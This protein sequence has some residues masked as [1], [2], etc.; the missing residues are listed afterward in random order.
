MYIIAKRSD[1]GKERVKVKKRWRVMG[2]AALAL[3]GA[4]LSLSML[5]PASWELAQENIPSSERDFVDFSGAYDTGTRTLRGT[6]RMTLT[7]RTGEALPEIVLRANMNGKMD[8]SL[9][10]SDVKINEQSVRCAADEADSTVLR[11]DYLWKP[12]ETIELSF[13]VLIKA[14]KTDGAAL[15]TLPKL[16]VY[17]NG[18]WR[19]ETYDALAGRCDGPTFDYRVK[20]LHVQDGMRAAFGGELTFSGDGNSPV[21]AAQ[22][23]GAR[24][25]TFALLDGCELRGMAEGVKTTVLAQDWMTARSLCARAQEALR[26]L[27]DIGLA[28]PFPAL[29][30]VQTDTG[31]EDG[32][33]GSGIVALSADGDSERLLQRLTRLIAR[34]TFGVLVGSDAYRE[35]WLS[36]S[37]ASAVELLAYRERKGLHAYETRFFENIEIAARVTRPYGVTVGAGTAAF[38][39]DSEMTQV[40]RDQGAAMLLGVEQAVGEETFLQALDRYA[41]ENAGKIASRAELESALNSASGSDWSGYLTDELSF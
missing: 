5:V 15:V 21:Y 23:Q 19:T 8:G 10:V 20:E 41:E 16:A 40:L 35:P 34:Q 28:Y 17:E 12:G 1:I 14:P 32:D 2:L 37:L 7:N 29:S 39:G 3:L 9:A 4:A 24:D 6:Q 27:A 22:M 18:A 36:H 38:G 33:I 13:L 25:I 26:S 30:I 31:R 11:M